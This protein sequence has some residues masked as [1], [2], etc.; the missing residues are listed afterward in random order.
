MGWRA[1]RPSSS[2]E[3]VAVA[4]S[5]A[6]ERLGPTLHL[7]ELPPI[8]CRCRTGYLQCRYRPPS[9]TL[10][11]KRNHLVW[12]PQLYLPFSLVLVRAAISY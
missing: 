12:D 8:W 5:A 11:S 9:F 1:L 2:L 4:A 10:V 3:S 6:A 7:V